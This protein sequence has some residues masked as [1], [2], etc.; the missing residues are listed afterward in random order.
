MSEALSETYGHI[1]GDALYV[2]QHRHAFKIYLGGTAL[3]V[4][5]IFA[6]AQT[7]AIK[8]WP[9]TEAPRV[10]IGEATVPL[11]QVVPAKALHTNVPWYVNTAGTPTSWMSDEEFLRYITVVLWLVLCSSGLGMELVLGEPLVA[12]LAGSDA[13]TPLW[14]GAQ[15]FFSLS[16]SVGLLAQSAFGFPWAVIGLWKFGFPETIGCFRRAFRIGRVTQES[17]CA[18]L[19]GIG[20]IVHH[21]SSAYFVVACAT[22]LMPLDRRI[23]AASLPLVVQHLFVLLKYANT[24]VY[25]LLELTIEVL[26]EIETIRCLKDLSVEN[27]YDITTR[28]CACSMLFAHWCYW[29]AGFTA[30][31]V[32]LGERKKMTASA[33]MRDLASDETGMDFDEFL[34]VIAEHQIPLTKK[35]ARQLFKEQDKDCSGALDKDEA[36]ELVRFLLF[37]V[38]DLDDDPDDKEEILE[39]LAHQTPRHVRLEMPGLG[40]RIEK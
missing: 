15:L 17:V 3:L 35:Q 4:V 12:R 9:A 30:I 22:H 2:S 21:C 27:G 23:V 24:P 6:A 33:T 7:V 10:P 13:L 25:F 11:S 31:P 18:Y 14:Q 29:A 38:P 37:L 8:M 40:S 16:I 39:C 32:W 1:V 28:G 34:D 5:G 26:W 36:E 19:N 20:T